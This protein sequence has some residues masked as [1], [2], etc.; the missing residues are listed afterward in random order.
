MSAGG[1]LHRSGVRIAPERTLRAAAEL[2]EQAGVGTLAV[3]DRGQLIGIV[4]D[5]D[6]V[7]RAMARGLPLDARIDA[8][9]SA[10][11]V[12]VDQGA[13]DGAVSRAFSNHGVRRLA[14]T[15]DGGEFVGILSLDD[16]LI[17]LARELS[18]VTRPI[19]SE[20]LV[21]DRDPRVPALG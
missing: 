21:A 19:T 10:P 15:G 14:V 8:V 12:T 3:V 7:R 2:M 18:D 1:M 13:D 17:R 9:M 20:V 16:V 6:L 5:R 4:T 11:V